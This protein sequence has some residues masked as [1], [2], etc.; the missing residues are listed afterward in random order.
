MADIVGTVAATLQFIGTVKKA[1]EL[2]EE[3]YQASEIAQQIKTTIHNLEI[4]LGSVH[5]L[6]SMAP[7]PLANNAQVILDSN[8]SR[9][10]FIRDELRSSTNCRSKTIAKFKLVLQNK[11][12]IMRAFEELEREKASLVLINEAI[13]G[14]ALALNAR[15]AD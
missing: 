5:D 11:S 8:N 3:I 1:W 13:L 4:V 6:H 14:Y 10:K 15:I 7:R 12:T 9:L 2:F